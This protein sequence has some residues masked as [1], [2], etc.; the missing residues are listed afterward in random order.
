[1]KVGDIINIGYVI[2]T[3]DGEYITANVGIFKTK[4]NAQTRCDRFNKII[5]S[6]NW[7]VKKVNL[8]VVDE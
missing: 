1:M 8:V 2:D 6:R 7:E 3:K 5:P 4:R